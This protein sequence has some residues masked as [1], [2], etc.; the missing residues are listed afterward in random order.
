[1]P[2]RT[3]LRSLTRPLT[4][5]SRPTT[6]A[7]RGLVQSAYSFLPTNALPE[8]PRG[9]GL[10]EIRGPYYFPVTATYLNELLSD[11]G[12]YVDGVKFAGGAFSLMPEERL[13]HLID[14][15]HQ[16]GTLPAQLRVFHLSMYCYCLDCY[17]STGGFIERVLS[18]SA[19]S[20]EVVSKYLTACKNMGFDILEISSGFLS[21]PTESWLNLIEDTKKHGLKPKPEVG[22]Q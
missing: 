10:T 16:H 7:R 3:S 15:A 2:A 18:S 4:T 17:V 19:G 20:P 21:I 12:A 5:A 6:S 13:K 11:W 22:I 8:K 1:M 9:K 14:V